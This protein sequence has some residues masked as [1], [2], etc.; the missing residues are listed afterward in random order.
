MTSTELSDRANVFAAL[1]NSLWNHRSTMAELA[2]HLRSQ[3]AASL[4]GHLPDVTTATQ[5]M[6]ACEERLAAAQIGVFHAM[7]E[8]SQHVP[9]IQPSMSLVDC[10]AVL[11]EVE[12]TI[13]QDHIEL[14][15][16]QIADL[17]H[18]ARLVADDSGQVLRG[19]GTDTETAGTYT[20]HGRVRSGL[21]SGLRGTA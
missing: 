14:Y 17:T 13:L 8:L 10:A 7:T 1:C 20:R 5:Q 16:E 9:A 18:A 11:D 2:Y 21:P 15:Q 4:A 19:L 6:L 12:Q 3:H